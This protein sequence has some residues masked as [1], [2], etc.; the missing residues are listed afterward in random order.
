LRRVFF[1]VSTFWLVAPII[2]N[3]LKPRDASASKT[4]PSFM[5]LH[6]CP[7]GDSCMVEM[8]FLL[9]FVG[10][11]LILDAVCNLEIIV[12]YRKPRR[13]HVALDIVGWK[14]YNFQSQ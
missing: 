6:I 4:E 10:V 9:G 2:H 12:N 11:A 3:I 5:Q 14:K 1:M 8:V 13:K 7:T